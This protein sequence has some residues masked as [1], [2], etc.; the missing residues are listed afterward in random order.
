MELKEQ[1]SDLSQIL[2]TLILKLTSKSNTATLVMPPKWKINVHKSIPTHSIASRTRHV[3]N[4][5]ITAESNASRWRRIEDLLIHIDQYPEARHYAIKEGAIRILLKTR[6][7][8]KDDQ[9]EGT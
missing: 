5:I 7:K 2:G 6:R 3:L 9:I 8:I 4:S 1:P